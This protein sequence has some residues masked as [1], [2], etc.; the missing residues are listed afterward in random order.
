[1]KELNGWTLKIAK[2]KLQFA[3]IFFY[4]TGYEIIVICCHHSD[5]LG[6]LQNFE[7]TI[8]FTIQNDPCFASFLDLFKQWS[9][10]R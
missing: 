7:N 2:Q 8:S 4:Q 10:K 6:L 3:H 1:M 5:L 9:E